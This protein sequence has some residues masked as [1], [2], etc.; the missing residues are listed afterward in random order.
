M[1]NNIYTIYDKKSETFSQPM[2][3]YS[4]AIAV[5]SVEYMVNKTGSQLYSNPADFSLFHIG[6]FDDV[7]GLLHSND[8]GYEQII[9]CLQLVSKEMRTFL[10]IEASEEE[11]MKAMVQKLTNAPLETV[12]EVMKKYH[13][14]VE[15]SLDSF[16]EKV[17]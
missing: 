1:I 8:K 15:E 3:Y 9:E 12:V 6:T 5:R 10:S 2:F 11:K 17:S 4:N 13:E 16:E 7:S 14:N